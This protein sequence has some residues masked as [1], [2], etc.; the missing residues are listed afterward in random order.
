MT[1]WLVL[2]LL[3]HGGWLHRVSPPVEAVGGNQFDA[4]YHEHYSYLSL[5][6]PAHRSDG[7]LGCGRCR[8]A[9]RLAETSGCGWPIKAAL[10]PHRLWRPC[11]RRGCLETLE[12]YV[13]FSSGQK[14]AKYGVL[15]FLMRVKAGRKRVLAMG[16]LPKATPCLITP[17]FRPSTAGSG[18]SCPQQAGHAAG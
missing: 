17:A 2:W 16:L 3:K 5:R 4:I 6:G 7:W 18:R 11:W 8:A 1:L 9:A 10:I 14:L 15:R 12:A 13:G